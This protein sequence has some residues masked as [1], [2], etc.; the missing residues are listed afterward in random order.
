MPASTLSSRGSSRPVDAGPDVGPQRH[1]EPL[2]CTR[3]CSTEDRSTGRAHR[4][5]PSG[6][7]GRGT[8]RR[9]SPRGR[10]RRTRRNSAAACRR[11]PRA[12]CRCRGPPPR[13]TCARARSP[14]LARQPSPSSRS[15]RVGLSLARRRCRGRGR[16]RPAVELLGRHAARRGRSCRRRAGRSRRCRR[17]GAARSRSTTA[18][19]RRSRPPSTPGPPGLTTSEPTRCSA[20]RRGHLQQGQ[21]DRPRRRG[22]RSRAAPAS[23]AHLLSAPPSQSF[24]VSFWS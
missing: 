3:F 4:R 14:L 21:L 24:Q 20:G 19:S 12:A 11:A 7:P 16:R 10:C 15:S 9:T 2:A 5:A 17:P 13:S 6:R 23:V 18:R 22:R 8:G 1:L